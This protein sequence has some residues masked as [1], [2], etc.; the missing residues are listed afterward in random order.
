MNLVWKRRCVPVFVVLLGIAQGQL[1]GNP[2]LAQF[3]SQRIEPPQVTHHSEEHPQAAPADGGGPLGL[4]FSSEGESQTP[5]PV[6]SERAS[7]ERK[8][9]QSSSSDSS[10]MAPAPSFV[11]AGKPQGMT[12]TKEQSDINDSNGDSNGRK[13]IFIV[14]V[15]CAVIVLL[16][17][18]L[19]VYKFI[20]DVR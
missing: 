20:T 6:K 15:I 13:M 7:T 16:M 11:Q 12:P 2:M 9:L 19:A 18:G 10:N 5:V 8:T 4:E 17:L 3:R 14:M 1:L